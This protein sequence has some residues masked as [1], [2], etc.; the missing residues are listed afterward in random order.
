MDSGEEEELEGKYYPEKSK[1]SNKLLEDELSL[2]ETTVFAYN[3]ALLANKALP[4][5]T[6]R[7]I[8]AVLA[9]GDG[10]Q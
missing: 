3:F 8:K 9:D 6:R 4:V 1:S 10:V 7:I 5:V 2:L